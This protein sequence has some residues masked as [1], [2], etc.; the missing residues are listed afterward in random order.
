LDKSFA[1]KLAAHI[2]A[3]RDGNAAGKSTSGPVIAK[4]YVEWRSK[5]IEEI[6]VRLDPKRLFDEGEKQVIYERAQAKCEVC[7]QPVDPSD[8]E[9]D[10][11]PIAHT[12]GGKTV[13][14]NARL[15]HS[16]C[17]PRG[18]VQTATE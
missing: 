6:G 12:L 18:P 1:P 13:V 10:H 2:L 15:V 7:K 4:Y 3:D 9:Y 16:T 17:H 8:A 5:I 11:F 14:E